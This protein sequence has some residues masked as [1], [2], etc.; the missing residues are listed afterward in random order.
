MAKEKEKEKEIAAKFTGDVSYSKHLIGGAS[1]YGAKKEPTY[2]EMLEAVERADIAS[3]RKEVLISKL[4]ERARQS[5]PNP[6]RYTVDPETG[7]IEI[8][9]EEGQ[10]TQKD[11]MMVSA[12]IKGK[13]GEYD[14]AIALI[15]AAKELVS[16]NQPGVAERPKEYLVDP[17][18]GGITHDPENGE[19]TLSEA[20]TISYSIQKGKQPDPQGQKSFLDKLE[21]MTQGLISQRIG[22]MLG[23]NNQPQPK[24][25]MTE[26]FERF[27]Q[28]EKFKERFAPASTNVQQLAQSGIR[29]EILKMLMEDERER[30]KM[31]YDHEGQVERNKQLGGI[32][33]VVKENLGDGVQALMRAADEIRKG[34]AAAAP[35]PQPSQQQ[36]QPESQAVQ[37]FQCENCQNPFGIPTAEGWEVVGCPHCGARYNREQVLGGK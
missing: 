25:T 11:A 16:G 30:L 26:F 20:R 33:S 14:A 21:D 8:D 2:E 22:A 23:G 10:Y 9:E 13:G 15:N 1:V 36:Q 31:Q 4:K 5:Q 27:D 29:G 17:E 34:G 6:K 3:A 37:S 35:Q 18:T 19:Y 24:D 28:V 7:K 32:A 12:S